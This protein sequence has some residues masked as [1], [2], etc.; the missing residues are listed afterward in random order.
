MQ[1]THEIEQMCCVKKGCN[2]GP[3]PIPQEGNWTQSREITDISGLTHGVGWCAPQQ[4]ACKLT[5]NVK[6]GVITS[7]LKQFY[8]ILKSRISRGFARGTL[9]HVSS[10]WDG[11]CAI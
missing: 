9:C 11:N 1:F 4:G 7:S 5:L 3:A 10:F 2:H 6:E 8:K